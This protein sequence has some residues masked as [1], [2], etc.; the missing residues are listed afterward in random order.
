LAEELWEKL[1]GE[2]MVIDAAWPTFDEKLCVSDTIEVAVQIN[3]KLRGTI[4][5]DA[6]AA[7]AD[8]IAQAKEVPNVATHLEGKE[9]RKEIYVPGKLVSLVIG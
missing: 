2:G 8:V 9:I 6:G 7:E 5:I 4:T 1:G 3:G